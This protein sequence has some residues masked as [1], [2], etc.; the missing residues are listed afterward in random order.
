M[1]VPPGY[2]SN[3]GLSGSHLCNGNADGLLRRPTVYAGFHLKFREEVLKSQR[4]V[5][6]LFTRIALVLCGQ[7]T[8]SAG[9]ITRPT[10]D[11]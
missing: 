9:S 3:S 7:I 6:Q 2:L 11:V 1:H 4:Y 8:R 5:F 10:I